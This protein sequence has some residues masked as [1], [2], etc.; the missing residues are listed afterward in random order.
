M[1]EQENRLSGFEGAV[2]EETVET[3]GSETLRDENGNELLFRST[4]LSLGRREC[5]HCGGTVKTGTAISVTTTGNTVVIDMFAL[6]HACL[7]PLD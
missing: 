7:E 2:D 1:V 4:D 3:G 5:E 6:R